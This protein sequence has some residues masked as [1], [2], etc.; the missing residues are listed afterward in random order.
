MPGFASL[1]GSALRNVFRPPLSTTPQIHSAFTLRQPQPS[2]PSTLFCS[3]ASSSK[4]NPTAS[5]PS[6]ASTS[7]PISRDSIPGR[8]TPFSRPGRHLHVNTTN[9]EQIVQQNR[10]P[11]AATIENHGH[12]QRP[13]TVKSRSAVLQ[14]S[15]NAPASSPEPLTLANPSDKLPVPQQPTAPP[16]IAAGVT[17]APGPSRGIKRRLGMVPR[18]A[19]G[20]YT[21]K[22]FKIPTL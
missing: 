19:A 21:N 11:T 7:H 16:G 10:H 6:S 12:S 3:P 9:D 2:N 1:A 14:S 20:G 17:P 15:R 5:G 22:K 4:P 8:A 18:A 13:S